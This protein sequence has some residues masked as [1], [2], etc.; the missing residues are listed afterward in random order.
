M[1]EYRVHCYN[2]IEDQE[3]FSRGLVSGKS[4]KDAANKVINDYGEECV[5][6]LY[7]MALEDSYTI[8][9]DTIKQQ[10]DL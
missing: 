6:D 8:E 1:I 7:L 10:F 9:L 4:Y 2:D 5:T 3:I